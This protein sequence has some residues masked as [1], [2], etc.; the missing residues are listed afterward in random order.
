MSTSQIQEALPR[1]SEEMENLSDPSESIGKRSNSSGSHRRMASY[2][3]ANVS[4][5]QYEHPNSPSSPPSSS[6]HANPFGSMAT[7]NSF[8]S[9]GMQTPPV[10][11]F[12]SGLTTS[13]SA[14]L[15][16][17]KAFVS[18]A[19][20]EGESPPKPWLDSKYR[21]KSDRRAYWIFVAAVLLGI[22]GAAA[23]IYTGYAAVPKGKYCLVMQDDF[24]GNSINKDL[25]YHEMETG[26]FGN[27]Q[28]EWTTD[29][30]NNSFVEDGS[31]YIVPTLTSDQF[32]EAAIT[33]G[34]TLNLT[35]DGR[36]T[37]IDKSDANCAAV[38][39]STLGTI[40]PPV[41][42]ARLITNFSKTIRYG[43]VEVR[44]RLPT[45]DW[46]WPAVWMMPSDSVYGVWPKSGEI[47][48]V[49]SKGNL[50]TKRSQGFNNQ[51]RST[52]HWGPSYD[53]DG[54]HKT[55]NTR[56]LLRDF[57]NEEYHTFGLE[58]TE[59]ALYTWER[60]PVHR[61]LAHKFD[62]DFWSIGGFQSVSSNGTVLHDPWSKADNPKIAPFDQYFYLIL[63]VAV[64]GTNGYFDNK[65]HPD[66][67]WSNNGENPA[68]DFYNAREKWLPTWPSDPKK[69]GLAVDY[70]KM[71][72]KC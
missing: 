46:L 9:G 62:K 26:G 45:G 15:R 3:S 20:P 65:D 71:W 2:G 24:D 35:A 63:N 58:W 19:I 6:Q 55:T 25:W 12:S 67:P 54:Y 52:L 5:D 56:S 33:N 36:C 42:S 13:S 48:I 49:E 38:S 16:H 43:R 50:A 41:Q 1:Q 51:M 69:R 57:Y 31:L 14:A 17:R 28:F 23:L 40:L 47:D 37:A 7:A 32:G 18:R 22:L 59:D 34:F 72:Q 68:S 4:P 8:P 53:Q 44:A 70:V 27:Q 39:N 64:G 11:T 30:I 10:G 66:M 61:V 21:A 29:S 60:S